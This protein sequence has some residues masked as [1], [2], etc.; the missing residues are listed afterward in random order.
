MENADYAGFLY[1]NFRAPKNR[2]PS[3]Q[4]VTDE[5]L[6]HKR[7]SRSEK[8]TIYL[9]KKKYDFFHARISRRGKG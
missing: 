2:P 8:N 7:N 3:G 1:A 5:A 4:K 6:V 9:I